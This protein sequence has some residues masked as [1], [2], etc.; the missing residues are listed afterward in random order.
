M[1]RNFILDRGI[2]DAIPQ[3]MRVVMNDGDEVPSRVGRTYELTHVGVTLRDPRDRYTT[4]PGRKPN[5]A[6]QIAETMWV[7]AGRDDIEWLSHYLPRAADYSDDGEIWRGAYGPRL[8]YWGGDFD[9]IAHIIDLLQNDGTTRRAVASIYDAEID[10]KPGKDIPCNNWLHFTS[11]LGRVD[12]HVA[13]RSNDL[14]WGWSGINMFEWSALQEIVAGY[15]GQTVGDLHFS[16]TSLHLYDRHWAKAEQLGQSVALPAAE[17]PRFMHPGISFDELVEAWFTVEQLIRTDNGHVKAVE[18]FPEPMLQSW[19]RVL[20]WWW[21]GDRG[22]LEPLEETSIVRACDLGVQP[23]VQAPLPNPG[24]PQT[25]GFVEYVTGLH[26]EKHAA[27]GDS[28]K[29]RGEML[30]IMANIARKVDRLGYNGAGDTATDTAIDLLVYLAK[31]HTWLTNRPA[32]DFTEAPNALIRELRVPAFT[33]ARELERLIT[34]NFEQLEMLVLKE[35]PERRKLVWE[36]LVEAYG[37]ARMLWEAERVCDPENYKH[38]GPWE[39]VKGSNSLNRCTNCG[40]V[41]GK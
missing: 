37:L 7:L 28:W 41:S 5:I 21:S 19:L 6:A 35:D 34:G 39:H 3:L 22:F 40:H 2:N 14:M 23:K 15:A 38:A 30:G 11:R 12:L 27:Y 17:S 33:D 32:S 8:R 16:I 26:D 20:Q 10:S 36:L 29:R 1:N 31:Y 18:D 9:Q 4:V 13:I 24:V 25:V